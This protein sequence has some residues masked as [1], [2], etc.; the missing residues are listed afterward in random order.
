MT[1]PAEPSTSPDAR[2]PEGASPQVIEQYKAKITDLGNLGARLTAVT[3]YYVSIVTALLGFLAFKEKAI[4]QIDSLVLFMVC[5]AGT[6]VSVLWFYSLSFFRGLFRA[7]LKVLEAIEESMPFQTFRSEFEQMRQSG[8]GSWLWIERLIPTVFG[9][10][11]IA[12][13]VARLVQS[14]CAVKS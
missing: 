12:L 11:F 4:S 6:S 10:F 5:G 1:T 3:A 13:I 2:L 14:L 9:L 7:K 8:L